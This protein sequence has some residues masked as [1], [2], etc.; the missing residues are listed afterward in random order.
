M[1]K[2]SKTV[3]TSTAAELKSVEILNKYIED[4]IRGS[5]ELQSS[6]DDIADSYTDLANVLQ[7]IVKNAKLFG[8]E[9]G[10]IEDISK[11]LLRNLENIGS[12]YY[13]QVDTQKQLQQIAEKRKSLDA[14]KIEAESQIN[15]FR[16]KGMSIEA[17]KAEQ[18]LAETIQSQ[19][20]L[21]LAEK[22]VI[23]LESQLNV[24][25]QAHKV[26]KEMGIDI[27]QISKEITSP[28]EKIM[29]FLDSVPVGGILSKFLGVDGKMEELSKKVLG[30]FVT[31]LGETGSV[32]KASLGALST[33]ASAFM[34]SLGPL[35][36]ILAGVAAVLYTIKKAFDLDQEVTD[37]AKGLAISKDS[38]IEL[39]N[40]FISIAAN[41]KVVGANT[42][43]L[44]ESY[45]E[46]AHSLGVTQLANA[47]MA[48]SQVY[49]KNQ[50]G[51]SAEEAADF[52]KF[53]MLSGRTAE[54][55]LA[56]IKTAVDSLSGGLLN[57]K[58]VAKDIAKS[59][60]AVQASYKGNIT[61]LAKAAVQAKKLGMT[62]DETKAI[63]DSFL[64]IE[65]SVG[66]E[67]EANVLTG[68]H[69]NMEHARELALQGK[70][71]EAAAEAVKQAGTYDEL[72]SMA[73]YQ[74]AAIAK[75]AG[76]TVDKLIEAAEAQKNLN[77][78]ANSLGI[79][80]RDNEKLTDEQIAQAA[81]LGNEEA[82]KLAIANQQAAAQEKLAMLGDKLMLIFSKLATPLME[83]LDPLMEM[84]D[85]I[86]PALQ[87]AI[88]IA[89]F[90]L[91][92]AAQL[93]SGIVKAFSGTPSSQKS[94]STIPMND[95]IIESDGL[96]VMSP[97]GT[98]S[99]NENDSIVAGTNISSNS[100]NSTKSSN[101]N[102]RI[103]TLLEK[104]IAKVDQPVQ[105]VMGG[106]VI[107][108]LDNRTTLRKSYNTSVDQGY[109][110]FG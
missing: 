47:E 27:K 91:K 79:T 63:A 20:N 93:L 106:K 60:K 51:L 85:T 15:A 66:A 29:S 33:G 1:A 4:Q 41:T 39:N 84:I 80:L 97:K 88:E 102:S 62:L 109:G 52:Q 82:K 56:V 14:D 59:S 81:S 48:E 90:P 92:A 32:G 36:P 86:F 24:L 67:M 35:L 26:A 10:D 11:S 61:A 21:N 43:A 100:G 12:E 9:W 107:D 44:A 23:A 2:A 103:E 75:A 76:T 31:K 30:T 40:Q 22:H 71:A 89:F 95:G 70:T 7:G 46:L 83:M 55:N 3:N 73:P 45:T 65:T 37:L 110:V 99:L 78:I 72:M 68:K 108:E 28:F 34:T 16:R 74:Q 6:I 25:N 8:E 19:E 64:D 87:V 38:A 101:N 96:S 50:I 94:P 17:E 42:K 57:Y 54:Q 104:L 53:S 105:I 13:E 77:S 18:S 98:Y 58:E 5:K 69:M 49:L